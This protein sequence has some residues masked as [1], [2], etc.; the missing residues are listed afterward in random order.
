M[1]FFQLSIFDSVFRTRR[2]PTKRRSPLGPR[3]RAPVK[4]DPY[5]FHQWRLIAEK[6]F[7]DRTDLLQYTVYWSKRS[8][9]RTLASCHVRKL[10]VA[11]A[12]ELSYPEHQRWIEPLLYHEM[13]HAVLGLSITHV[14]GKRQWHGAEFKRLEQRHPEIQ[15]LDRWIKDGGW[16][17][18]VRSD[19]SKRAYRRRTQW[20]V[21]E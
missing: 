12:R 13:C 5:L 1:K 19:R 11:V 7:P 2:Q 18:A 20:A 17:S 3:R 14:N 15:A 21:H 16:R 4:N 10:L 9:K 6:Y 8:Q